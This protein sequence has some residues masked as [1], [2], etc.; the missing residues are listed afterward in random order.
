MVHRRLI[1]PALA[2]LEG[3]RVKYFYDL[4]HELENDP[5]L[6]ASP[7]TVYLVLKETLELLPTNLP[8]NELANF[9]FDFVATNEDRLNRVIF[10]RNFAHDPS[11]IRSVT[12]DF[13]RQVVDVVMTYY[14]EGKIESHEQRVHRISWPYDK[15]DFPYHDDED[16]EEED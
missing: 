8:H 6:G 5:R 11:C 12:N 10:S 1:E 14:M 16:E 2:R 13:V 15:N 9:L 4:V 7:N 3:E